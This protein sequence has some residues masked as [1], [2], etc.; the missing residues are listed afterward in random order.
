M[1]ILL[2]FSLLAATAG[3]EIIDRIAV[4]IGDRV[5]TESMILQQLRL[6]AFYDGREPDVSPQSKKQA[7]ET[8]IS[9][10]LLIQEMDDTRYPEPAMR[11]ALDALQ[12][13]L[14]PRYGGEERFREALTRYRVTEDQLVNFIQR[15]QRS[16]SFIDLRFKRGQTVTT[17]EINRFYQNDFQQIWNRSNSGKPV[18]GLEEVSDDI[19]ELILG[20]KTDTAVEEWLKETQERSGIRI[21][22]EVFQ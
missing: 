1:R 3:A 11:E 13:E 8:L 5:I 15:M 16:V 17:E 21:R 20:R 18:P 9:Q 10:I 7:V 6:S 12:K 22:E 2:A 14:I 4:N 19:E